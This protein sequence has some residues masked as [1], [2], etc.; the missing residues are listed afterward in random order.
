MSPRFRFIHTSDWHLGQHFMGKSRAAEHEAFFAWLLAKVKAEKVD[1]VIVAGD[2]FDTGTPPSYARRLYHDVVERMADVGC[3]LIVLGGNHDSVAMLSESQNLF[4]R[5]GV[6]VVPA[7]SENPADLVLPL[8]NAEGEVAALLCALPFIRPRDVVSIR[9]GMQSADIEM[10]L[11][12][13]IQQYYG[14]VYAAAEARAQTMGKP[15]PII[16]TGHLTTFGAS[17]SESVRDIYVGTLKTFP[18]DAFPAFDYLALGHIHRPQK[19]GSN[20]CFR[21]S[22]SPIPL[23]FDEVNTQKEVTLV[24]C[25]GGEALSFTSVPIPLHQPMQVLKGNLH[26]IEAQLEQV[27]APEH[28]PTVWLELQVTEDGYLTDLQQRLER[29]LEDKPVEVLRIMRVQEAAQAQLQS[30]AQET[31]A[32][33]SPEEVFARRLALEELAEGEAEQLTR[34]HDEVVASV[35]AGAAE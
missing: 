20:P 9:A 11:Q 28:V 25:G 17:V 3:Q 24:E 13:Q 21:Y 10:A 8:T 22:G 18:S 32:E 35:R 5:F 2:I 7:I 30:E 16:G 23:S 1:A 26:H 15:L 19:V 34:L 4:K 12:Q 14:A 33:L 27:Q 6:H 29:V 31:L